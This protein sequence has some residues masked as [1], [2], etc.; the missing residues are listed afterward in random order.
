MTLDEL[1]PSSGPL[2]VNYPEGQLVLV[3]EGDNA[4]AL[5]DTATE[6][7]VYAD[8]ALLYPLERI[9]RTAR[10]RELGVARSC[11]DR[12]SAA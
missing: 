12:D 1:P 6:R 7:R 5:L 11:T 9:P 2:S 8:T 4:F 3:L 10:I